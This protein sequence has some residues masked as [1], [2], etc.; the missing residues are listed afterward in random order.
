MKQ[1]QLYGSVRRTW[2]DIACLKGGRR[3][4]P[5]KEYMYTKQGNEFSTKALTKKSSLAHI[6]ILA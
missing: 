4:P 6:L 5:S 3:G 1:N 2:P